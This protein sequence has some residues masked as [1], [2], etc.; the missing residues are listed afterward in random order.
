MMIANAQRLLRFMGGF[1][2]AKLGGRITR[3]KLDQ[4]Q[5]RRFDWLKDNVLGKSPFYREY[6]TLDLKDFPIVDKKIHMENFNEIN[7]VSLDRDEAL[8]VAILSEQSRDFQPLYR[9]YSVGLSSGTSGS[10]G[11]FVVSDLERSEWA[12]YMVGKLLPMKFQ[13]H[14]IAFFLRANNNLYETVNGMM[15]QFRF[16]DLIQPLENQIDSILGYQPTVLIGPGSVLAKIAQLMPEL[17]LQIIIAV[18]EV[19]ESEDRE[20]IQQVYRVEVD[21]VYQCTEGFLAATCKH[22]NLHL[23]EDIAIIEKQWIDQASGRFSPVVTDLRRTTQPIVRY[24]LDDILIEDKRQCA[25]GSAMTRLKKIEGRRDDILI[26]NG[27]AGTP[28]DV[29]PDFVRNSIISACENLHEYRVVQHS[30]KLLDIQLAPFTA[31]H[32]EQVK[33]GLLKL[34]SQLGVTLPE[35]QFSAYISQNAAQKRRRVQRQFNG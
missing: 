14:R 5:A 34:W 23:N 11:L 3:P 25:C 1:C 17:Q 24:L 16:F 32:C 30:E 10:R 29:Y 7:S 27:A 12:G 26:L 18:A 13:R 19:L 9:G 2:R 6:Q 35:Y 20:R 33:E 22:G 4:L 31:E 21:Q 8:N 15:M 28:V